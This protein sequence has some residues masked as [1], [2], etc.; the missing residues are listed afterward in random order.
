MIVIPE[1]SI[2]ETYFSKKLDECTNDIRSLFLS[3]KNKFLIT[4]E[5]LSELEAAV[6]D[7]NQF[8]GLISYLSDNNKVESESLPQD[9]AVSQFVN[10]SENSKKH[11]T[12]SLTINN[13]V[14]ESFP[15]LIA[16][17]NIEK[18]N[19]EWVIYHLLCDKVISLNHFNFSTNKKIEIF[20]D[21][22]ISVPNYIKSILIFNRQ[23][24]A[25]YLG[26]LKGKNIDY[27]TLLIKY[28]NN[29]HI[30]TENLELL[31]KSL[32]GKLKLYVTSNSKQIHE[33]KLFIDDLVITMDNSFE[34]LL[35]EEPTW[36]IW[37]EYDPNCRNE[38]KK[39]V[40]NF[41][42]F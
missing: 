20:F 15:Y 19:R 12:F 23:V 40:D 38:W 13:K 32:G 2:F 16:Y 34:N 8:Q 37:V 28:W 24:D 18:P 36:T 11:F 5:Y 3:K 4:K 22:I 26:K 35:I 25:K 10:I 39:K 33:R 9:S 21:T 30:Y 27:H 7:I 1:I 31:K 42:S 41:K 6:S 29:R 17:E 14:D